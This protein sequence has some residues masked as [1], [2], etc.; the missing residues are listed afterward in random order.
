M[1]SNLKYYNSEEYI[2][3]GSYIKDVHGTVFKV[4]YVKDYKTVFL[5]NV[6]SGEMIS[7]L[8]SFCRFRKWHPVETGEEVL[9]NI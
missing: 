9:L 2:K 7:S 6:H 3:V 1:K 8:D 5:K 4:C